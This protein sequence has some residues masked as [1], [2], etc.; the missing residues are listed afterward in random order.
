MA[1][2]S[3]A[4]NETR[5]DM[6]AT[7]APSPNGVN[8]G[9]RD[10]HGRFT[11]GNSGG[12]GNL[13]IKAVAAWRSALVRVVSPKDIEAV[14]KKLLKCAKAGDP[15]A[16]REVLDRCLGKP[17]QDAG[18]PGGSEKPDQVRVNVD[19]GTILTD[20]MARLSELPPAPGLRAPRELRS[21]DSQGR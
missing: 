21:Q 1:M 10:A 15:W 6:S 7:E 11:R 5:A 2:V 20:R 9:D 18:R 12:P 17:H 4:G 8:G 13:H 16:I 19:L 14:L 3:G